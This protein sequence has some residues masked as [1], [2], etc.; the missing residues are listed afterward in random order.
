MT[1]V[2]GGAD[3]PQVTRA[4][5][6]HEDLT[7]PVKEGPREVLLVA[8]LRQGNLAAADLGGAVEGED[9]VQH[10]QIHLAP[11]NMPFTHRL[12]C[13]NKWAP[14]STPTSLASSSRPITTVLMKVTQAKTS[15]TLTVRPTPDSLSQVQ[16]TTILSARSCT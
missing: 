2:E 7:E 14:C 15:L 8:A 11:V 13:L 3:Q 4:E 5:R 10:P 1:G 9:P 16:N 6:R 12:S